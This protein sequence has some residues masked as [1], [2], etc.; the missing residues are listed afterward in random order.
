MRAR[1][2]LAMA[3]LGLVG[4]LML[5]VFPAR[6]LVAQHEER[7][8]VAARVKSLDDAN[9]SLDARVAALRTDAE[10]ERLARQ[11]YNLVR[12]NEVVFDIL[13]PDPAPA[14]RPAPAKAPPDPGW[15]RRTLSRLVDI[16]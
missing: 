3:V 7:R 2:W 5:A 12:P 9:R 1:A 6:A 14:G 4:V 13:T 8:Q 10:I 15:V 16:F 11:H